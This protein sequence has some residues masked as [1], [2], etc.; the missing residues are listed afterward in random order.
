M[1][2]F[3][4]TSSEPAAEH[5]PQQNRPPLTQRTFGTV[6]D[7]IVAAGH[8]DGAFDHLPGAG[9]PLQLD[10]DALVPEEDRVGYRMLRNAGFGPPWLELQKAIR[11]EQAGIERWLAS[12]NGR[13]AR[14]SDWEQRRART[15]YRDKLTALY[16]LI[17]HYNLKVPAA[18]GQMPL[19]RVEDEMDRLG[20][21]G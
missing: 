2:A 7:Q 14:M 12:A 18:I 11:D 4:P 17:L 6:V 10:D 1:S 8:A 21:I 13:W 20:A 5:E 3:R 15:E 19:I 9:K 16:R